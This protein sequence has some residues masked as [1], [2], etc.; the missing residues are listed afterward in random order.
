MRE[1]AQSQQDDERMHHCIK[2]CKDAC[3]VALL[4]FSCP[5][6][7]YYA[8]ILD[9]VKLNTDIRVKICNFI[10]TPCI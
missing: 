6:H 7:S 3:D 10:E 1:D 9:L 4:H 2:C 5:V 8:Q